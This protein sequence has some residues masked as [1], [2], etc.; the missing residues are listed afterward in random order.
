MIQTVFGP[1]SLRRPRPQEK[2]VRLKPDGKKEELSITKGWLAADKKNKSKPGA[3]KTEDYRLKVKQALM[4]ASIRQQLVDLSVGKVLDP[5][6]GLPYSPEQILNMQTV[7]QKKEQAMK[8]G[9][10]AVSTSSLRKSTTLATAAKPWEQK[11]N[12]L[13]KFGKRLGNSK[14]AYWRL[15]LG[16]LKVYKY[17]TEYAGEKDPHVYNI[18]D[19]G[20]DSKVT[21]RFETKDM[22]GIQEAFKDGYQA[23]VRLTLREREHGPVFLYSKDTQTAKSW[24]RAIRMSKFLHQTQDREALAYVVGR[25]A[26]STVSKGWNALFQYYQ[27]MEDTRRLMKRL[28]M[29]LKSLELSRGWNKL[30][31]VYVQKTMAEKRRK[32]Q[33]E[34]AARFLSEKMMRLSGQTARSP[35]LVRLST[36]NKVQT[37]FRHYRQDMIFDR[38]YPLGTTASTRVQQMITGSNMMA[39]FTSLKAFDVLART[40]QGSGMKDFNDDPDS[41]ASKSS[42]YSEVDVRLSKLGLTIS[43][44]FTMLSFSEAQENDA[45]V[46]GKADW[47]HYVNVNQISSVVLHSERTLGKDAEGPLLPVDTCKGSWFTIYG[48]RVGWGRHARTIKHEDGKASTEVYGAKD[49]NAL[50]QALAT[51]D[52]KVQWFHMEVSVRSADAPDLKGKLQ[53]AGEL[54]IGDDAKMA[55]IHGTK[56]DVA[57]SFL[58]VTFLGKQFKYRKSSRGVYESKYYAEVPLPTGEQKLAS[59]DEME[60]GIDVVEG[61]AEDPNTWRTMWSAKVPFWKIFMQGDEIAMPSR[62]LKGA[63]TS[64]FSTLGLGP[65]GGAAGTALNTLGLAEEEEESITSMASTMKGNSL[66]TVKRVQLLH[67]PFQNSEILPFKAN[68]VV[69]VTAT[70]RDAPTK[71]PCISPELLGR[72]STTALFSSHRGAWLSPLDRKQ[73]N[74]A[75]NFVELELKE[76]MFPQEDKMDPNRIW[77]Y[78]IQATCN[79]VCLASRTLHRPPETWCKIMGLDS[80]KLDFKSQSIFVPLP[81]G[82]W[83]GEVDKMPVVRMEIVRTTVSVIPGYSYGELMQNRNKQSAAPPAPEVVYHA[84]V[85]LEGLVL[86]DKVMPATGVILGRAGKEAPKNIPSRDGIENVA[87]NDVK[88]ALLVEVTLRDRD[89]ARL[90]A[91]QSQQG[92][93]CVGDKAMLKVEEAIT[94]P[95]S[96][97]DFR[98]RLIPGEYDAKNAMD[99]KAPLRDPSLSHEYKAS[100][101]ERLEPAVPFKQRFLPNNANDI[102]PYKFVMPSTEVDFQKQCKPGVYWRI[103]ERL[104][105]KA[106]APATDADGKPVRKPQVVDSLE[107]LTKNIPVTVLAVYADGTCD[108]EIASNFLAEWESTPR[109][110]YSIEGTV[111]VGEH[112]DSSAAAIRNAPVGAGDV[113]ERLR[114]RVVLK[115]V[116]LSSITAV[117]MA[118]F[119]IYDA[120]LPKSNDPR[121]DDIVDIVNTHPNKIANDYNPRF[122]DGLADDVALGGQGSYRIAAGPVPADANPAACTYEWSMSVCAPSEA[123]M[124]HFVTMLRQAVRMDAAE[125]VKKLGEFKQKSAFALNN[126]PYMNSDMYSSKSGHLEVI[127][128]EAAHLRPPKVQK[129]KDINVR[130]EEQF[131][132]SLQPKAIFT[133]HYTDENGKDK[134]VIY[135]GSKT[136]MSPALSGNDPNWGEQEQFKGS[137]GWVFKTPQLDAAKMKDLYFTIELESNTYQQVGLPLEKLGLIEMDVFGGKDKPGRGSAPSLDLSSIDKPFNNLWLGLESKD[138]FN[139]LIP[140]EHGELHIMTLWKPAVETAQSRRMPKTVK[141]WQSY[142]LKQVMRGVTMHDPIY[143]L[144]TWKRGYDPNLEREDNPQKLSD[145]YASHV[146]LLSESIP[147]IDSSVRQEIEKWTLFMEELYKKG[148][149]DKSLQDWRVQWTKKNDKESLK[150][151]ADLDDLVRLGIPIKKRHIYWMELLQADKVQQTFPNSGNMKKQFQPADLSPDAKEAM[152]NEEAVG[153]SL[154]V[155]WYNSLLSQGRSWQNDAMSQVYEDLVAAASWERGVHHAFLQRHYQRLKRAQDVCIAL[156]NFCRE[157]SDDELFYEGKKINFQESTGDEQTGIA[158]TESML[159]LA[160]HLIVAQGPLVEGRDK[161]AAEMQEDEVRAFW[162]IYA[163]VQGPF[164][165]YYGVTKVLP[166][167]NT[168]GHITHEIAARRGA[169]DDILQ[170]NCILSRFDTELWTHLNA[171]GF[172][173]NAFFYPI[174]MRLFAFTLPVT[175]LYRFWDMVF[176]DAFREDMPDYKPARH[177]LIDLAWVGLSHT[178]EELMQCQSAQE[179]KNCLMNFFESIINPT[180]MAEW[181]AEAEEDLWDDDSYSLLEKAKLAPL[182]VMDYE[183]ALRTWDRYLLQFINQNRKLAEITAKEMGGFGGA[184]A[185]SNNPNATNNAANNNRLGPGQDAR[186]TTRTVMKIINALQQQFATERYEVS[187]FGGLVRQMPRELFD[188]EHTEQETTSVLSKLFSYGEH[189][190]ESFGD[191]YAQLKPTKNIG[192]PTPAGASPEP[193]KI[194]SITWARHVQTCIGDVWGQDEVQRIFDFFSTNFPA[195]DKRMSTNEFFIALICCSKGTVSEKAIA[196]FYLYAF[197]QPNEI[198]ARHISPVTHAAGSI[199]ERNDGKNQTEEERLLRAPKDEEVKKMAL[200]FQIHVFSSGAGA[201]EYVIGEVFITS[202]LPYM[203]AG[204]MLSSSSPGENA[205]AYTIWGSEKKL[206]PGMRPEQGANPDMLISDHG[207]RPQMGTANI[208]IKWMP[209]NSQQPDVGQLTI[210]LVSIVFNTRNVEAPQTKN[211]RVTVH[212]YDRGNQQQIARWDPRS[213]TKKMT[214]AVAMG[215]AVG[216]YL[217]WDSTMSRDPVTGSLR[218]KINSGTHGWQAATQ[219][220]PGSWK[221]SPQYGEQLS[222]PQVSFR[223]DLV[224]RNVVASADDAK[225]KSQAMRPNAISLQACRVLTV[226]ILSRGLHPISHRQ[227]CLIADQAFNRAGAVPGILDAIIVCGTIPSD[228]SVSAAIEH[229]KEKSIKY[230]DVKKQILKCHEWQVTQQCLDLDLLATP[231]AANSGQTE[232]SPLTLTSLEIQDPYAGQRKT[233]WIRICRAGDG[234]RMNYKINIDTNGNLEKGDIHLDMPTVIGSTKPEDQEGQMMMCLTKAEFVNCLINSPLLSETLRQFSTVDNNT[235]NVPQGTELKLDVTIADPTAEEADDDMM[236]SLNVRQTV[237]LEIWDSDYNRD[238]FLGECFLP[239]LSSIGTQW[240][241]FVLPVQAAPTDSGATRYDTRKFIKMKAEGNLT[242][243][244]KWELPATQ[245]PDLKEGAS[246]EE[247]VDHATKMHTGKLTLKIVEAK[248]LRAADVSF[249]RNSSDPYVVMYVKNDAFTSTDSP[250][251]GF[252]RYGWHQT[253]TRKHQEFWTTKVIKSTKNPVW[254]EEKEFEL[255]TGA[256]E[257]RV[258]QAFHLNLTS[259]QQQKSKDDYNLAVLGGKDELRIHFGE[260]TKNEVGRRHDVKIYMGENMHQFKDKLADACRDEARQLRSKFKRPEDIKGPDAKKLDQLETFAKSVSYRHVVM[261]FVPSARL[262]EL[263]QQGKA[264]ISGSNTYEYKRRYRVEEQDPSSW[265]PLDPVCPFSHYKA[266]YSF[267]RNVQQRLRISDGTAAY[268]EKNN[269]LRLFEQQQKMYLERL[270][271]LNTEQKCFGYAKYVHP[272]DF[273]STEWRPAEVFRSQNSGKN[274]SFQVSYIHTPLIATKAKALED[275]KDPTS[276][277]ISSAKDAIT[278]AT[279][280]TDKVAV[281]TEVVE[282]ASVVLAPSDPKI[283]MTENREHQELLKRAK[284]LKSEGNDDAKIVKILND[285]LTRSYA[286]SSRQENSDATGAVARPPALTLADVQG[287][288]KQT[289]AAEE[290]TPTGGAVVPAALAS[291]TR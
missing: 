169:T 145:A 285:E 21:C 135:K 61:N 290:A 83:S 66:N 79:G 98:K 117:Q 253:V 182:H 143:D 42:S 255:Q 41:F 268:K 217:E 38:A 263:A 46:L 93:I 162:I 18:R 276:T 35:K 112:Q 275:A 70:I 194:D 121:S 149:T 16:M 158:Y 226:G 37:L 167:A 259:S 44:S 157:G 59:L 150:L 146:K 105:E 64:I 139:N 210:T 134:E 244:A 43:E 271:D 29:R 32:E 6:S 115:G 281:G 81:P 207:V 190:K 277:L 218:H 160:F 133:L 179:A 91:A 86:D 12:L 205:R 273:G 136:Q 177:G 40:L 165:D 54:L 17:E 123:D 223:R 231:K 237:L 45:T 106:P 89:Y 28:A 85:F 77:R 254:N 191:K 129:Q 87:Q 183:K 212:T 109:K 119:N 168:G 140:K 185:S 228:L 248:G 94:Y 274:K 15:E 118:S 163:L 224:D 80:N 141:G 225:A 234:K 250:P 5:V 227:G 26:G 174:F 39:A 144:Q 90:H 137:G 170:L 67:P 199:I 209:P 264:S 219:D 14:I 240:K 189:F 245:V 221:W 60:L 154:A 131:K 243:E 74:Y 279:K 216:K 196:L 76:L 107:F 147:Y 68:A 180:T 208:E 239:P 246:L 265:Q 20:P 291:S 284:F 249:R 63:A 101:L 104:V 148:S 75:A 288:L 230:T 287:A 257:K 78:S 3:E 7:V 206:P 114:K 241:R 204:S 256:F 103:M 73:Q 62:V 159:V 48:P 186:V 56:S 272:E 269:R 173:L 11:R 99:W 127:L 197:K 1:V 49:G 72:G 184:Q 236:D 52:K 153:A 195:M 71:K 22:I 175:T 96:E 92:V 57:E 282:E 108:V 102:I 58:V 188:L 232:P 178:K 132:L 251:Q 200:H 82:C 222:N 50:G 215:P 19:Q 235:K 192:I 258:H 213:A 267:G 69:Q 34:Y 261:V 110:Q 187:Q 166:E 9:T 55:E 203:S 260:D 88:V 172:S 113:G 252:D 233:L 23:R 36:V 122:M 53:E 95:E 211:P 247:R 30:R 27:E 176:G 156:I 266:M 13:V 138:K 84:D 24:E 65:S 201:K 2:L 181:L 171:V 161:T 151:M 4:M 164:K 51:G 124:F 126:R 289:E 229:F 142:D 116:T 100:G 128:V 283:L 111:M 47:G 97:V 125:Q 193:R 120:A 198:N 155:A 130:I 280:A 286:K 202:L 278:Q 33:Q 31:L 214:A 8:E 220:S 262:R 238:D 25:V 270:E 242:V 10:T 152:E